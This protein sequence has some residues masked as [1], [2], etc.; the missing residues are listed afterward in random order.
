MEREEKNSI[1]F[2]IKQKTSVSAIT[3]SFQNWTKADNTTYMWNLK[4]K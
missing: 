1:L 4:K 3:A 2:V